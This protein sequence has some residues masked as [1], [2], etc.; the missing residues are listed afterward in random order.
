MNDDIKRILIIED[1][2]I[3]ANMLMDFLTAPGYALERTVEFA[4]TPP[5]DDWDGVITLVEK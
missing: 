5:P 1:S 3:F 2:D 4:R